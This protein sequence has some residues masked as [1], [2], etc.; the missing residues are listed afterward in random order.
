MRIPSAT[1]RIQFHHEFPFNA[2]RS[3]VDYLYELGISD[4]YASPIFKARSGSMHG[5]DVLDP[6][7]INPELGTSEQFNDLVHLIQQHHMGWLQDIVPNHMAYDSQNPY[8]MDIMENGPAAKNIAV[9]DVEW[10]IHHN[11]KG[12]VLAPLLGSLYGECLGNGELKLTYDRAGL[13]ITYFELEL[14]IRLESY[15][16]FITLNIEQLTH[17]LGQSHPDLIKLMGVMYLIKNVATET[18]E[19]ERY[20]QIS[21]VKSLMWELYTQNDL[22]KEFFKANLAYFNGGDENNQSYDSLDQLLSNQF[23]RLSFWKVA[24]EEINYRRFFAVNELISVKVENPNVF[25][26]VHNLIRS[27]VQDGKITGLRVDH[28]DGLYNPAQYLA[29]LEEI[30]PD[31][32]ITVEKILELQEDLPTDWTI[33]GTSGYDF[34]NYINGI[35]C[36]PEN[37]ARIQDIYQ[38]FT[39]LDTAYDVLAEQKKQLIIEH[40]LA[41][42]VANLVQKLK[43]IAAQDREGID[44]TTLGLAKVLREVLAQF[45]VYR[46]YTVG[47]TVANTDKTYVEKAIAAAAH[48]LPLLRKELAYLQQLLLRQDKDNLS[49]EQRAERLYFVMKFQQLTGPLMAKGI[50]DT[51]LYIYNRLISLNE[52]GGNPSHFGISLEAFHRFNRKRR[53][54]WPHTQNATA[55]HDTKRGEDFRARINILSELSDE[56]HKQVTQWQKLNQEHKSYINNRPIPSLNDEYFLYQTL[57]GALPFDRSEPNFV[58]RIKQ[59]VIKAVREA[60][61]ETTWLN[62]NKDYEAGYLEF[63]DKILAEPESNPFLQAFYPFQRRIAAYGIYNSLSQVLVKCAAPGI[64]DLYQGCEL[65]DLSLVDPDNRRPVDYAKRIS[66][67]Q[68]IRAKADRLLLLIEELLADRADGRIKLFLTTQMLQARKA[69]PAVFQNGSYQPLT[70]RGTLADSIIAF[71]RCYQD[72]TVVAIAPRFLTSLIEPDTLPLGEIWQDT[73]IEL[74]AELCGSWKDLIT[75]ESLSSECSVLAAQAFQHFPGALL[76]YQD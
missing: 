69:F 61:V 3:I 17:K 68:A 51:L 30:A 58:D 29:R 48:Q 42:D 41:G 6:N 32:Y 47:D 20:N 74:P 22:I 38:Q 40:D 43:A 64:P 60:K 37:E 72:T 35:F 44:F 4:I 9:F 59:Y 16:H 46:T 71:A 75:S 28:I 27:L 55:T 56:W 52:V 8:L 24:S 7:Q 15:L 2:A 25:E 34:L 19:E 11:L 39:G 23:Y 73:C 33:K 26:K 70:V 13:K 62:V 53:E 66:I 21:F 54:R 45:P 57:T 36:K 76:L 50:E 12:R 63:I 31:T 49:S 65:W 14:P 1:Y 10:K 5:Y 67:L 18:A